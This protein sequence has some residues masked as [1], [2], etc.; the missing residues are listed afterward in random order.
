V[1][2]RT[3]ASSGYA[4]KVAAALVAG[5][6]VVGLSVWASSDPAARAAVRPT[7]DKTT[8]RL[9]QLSYDSNHDGRPDTWTDMDGTRPLR[10]RIDRDGDGKIDR[11]E[12]Y[13]ASG[14]LAKVAFS[15]RNDGH[16]DAWISR[17]AENGIQRVDIS[18]SGD[19]HKIDRWEYYQASKTGPDGRGTLVRV[20][21]DGVGDGRPHRWETY[22]DGV[23]ESV[24]FDEDGD[25]KPDRRLVYL[26]GT[27]S[28]IESRPDAAGRFTVQQRVTP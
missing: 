26:N 21:E 13:D 1:E 16:A 19:E 20:E 27:L 22:Q 23:L 9:T 7:Y 11:W 8:G 24:A 28:V 15:R 10:A 18:S 17:P 6:A 2:K 12:E 25:G 14:A 5:S 4:Y 3:R